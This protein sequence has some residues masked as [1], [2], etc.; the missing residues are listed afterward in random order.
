M[1]YVAWTK[2]NLIKVCHESGLK[3]FNALPHISC[4]TIL[5][6]GPMC[7]ISCHNFFLQLVVDLVKRGPEALHFGTRSGILQKLLNEI[8]KDDI[9]V[10]LNCIELLT[11]LATCEHGLNYLHDQ[12]IVPQLGDMLT[13]A[14]SDPL[15]GFLIPGGCFMATA[16]IQNLVQVILL[17]YIKWL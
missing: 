8:H 4:I 17:Y 15:M 7:R 3:N 10:Q 12:G 11:R 1:K 13:N 16:T 14:E 6:Q 9:L 2:L 5:L